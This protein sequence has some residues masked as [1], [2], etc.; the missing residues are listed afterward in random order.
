MKRKINSYT[1]DF[2]LKVVQSRELKLI[3]ELNTLLQL[4][5]NS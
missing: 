5:F 4:I 3:P 1:D 2:K